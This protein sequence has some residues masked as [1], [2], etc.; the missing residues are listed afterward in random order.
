MASKMD[1]GWSEAAR[2]TLWEDRELILP[3]L[4]RGHECPTAAVVQEL[5]RSAGWTY[6]SYYLAVL[7]DHDGLL[8]FTQDEGR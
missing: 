5:C 7:F 8:E 6:N 3:H 1:E 2:Q 4:T